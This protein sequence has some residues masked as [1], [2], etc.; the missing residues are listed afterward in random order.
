VVAAASL[1]FGARIAQE[2]LGIPT[3]TV[4]LQP[5][6]FRSTHLPPVLPGPPVPAW[7]PR[8][9]KRFVYWAADRLVI[10]PALAPEINAF[11][12]ELG[13]P[14]VRRLFHGWWNSPQ[15]VLG[16]FPAWFG[17]PQP[18]WPPQTVLTGFP[19]YDERG[20]TEAPGELHA[21]LDAGEPPVVF[22]PG[23][24]MRHGRAFFAESVAACGL[25][26]RRGLLLTR[27][28]EQ[29]PPDL[30]EGVRH[31]EYVPFSQLLP[32]AAA[33]VHHGGIGT[34]AQ[35]LAAGVPQLV[36]PMGFDQPDNAARVVHAGAGIRLPKNASASALRGAIS[37][38][39]DDP[40]YRAAAAAMAARLAD[41]RDDNL[42]V[43]ELERV[44]GHHYRGGHDRTM[45]RSAGGAHRPWT[46]PG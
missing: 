40:R 7:A 8:P 1:A 39:I 18:D 32:R 46:H 13:L 38:V 12:T 5:G 36:M 22:T 9:W 30:P 43:D 23:S 6:V 2:R 24:A 21:F 10:D 11:R 27:Y 44:A 17:P 31:F 45:D 3:A 35:G 14:P 26:G 29:V 33:L 4:H 20:A 34:L 41:E 42:V 19:L 28:R 16:L 15:L 37:R 25:L